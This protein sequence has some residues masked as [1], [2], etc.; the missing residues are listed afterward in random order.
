VFITLLAA[1][2]PA[3]RAAQMPPAVALRSEI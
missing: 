1:I 2:P 3:I